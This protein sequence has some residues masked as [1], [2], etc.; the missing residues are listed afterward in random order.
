M[1]ALRVRLGSLLEWAVAAAFFTATIGVAALILHGVGG[2]GGRSTVAAAAVAAIADVPP[3]VPKGA[4]SVPVLTFADA[5][6]VRLGDSASAVT[7]RLGRAA[8]TG[9]EEVDAGR[10]GQRLTRFYDYAGFRFVIVFEPFERRGE[11]RVSAIYL[12]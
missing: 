3:A 9:R 12:P 2:P 1:D 8:E 11:R 6:E 10:L 7:D 5:K 4:V